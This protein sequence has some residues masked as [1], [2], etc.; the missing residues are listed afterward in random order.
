MCVVHIPSSQS[1]VLP[2]REH[3]CLRSLDLF[4]VNGTAPLS[5]TAQPDA[6]GNAVPLCWEK[7]SVDCH[8]KSFY[9]LWSHWGFQGQKSSLLWKSRRG[10]DSCGIEMWSI[11]SPSQPVEEGKF[12]RTAQS[13]PLF[14]PLT[15]T[16]GSSTR[17]GSVCV[18]FMTVSLR[19][20]GR[21]W[22]VMASSQGWS[23]SLRNS[24]FLSWSPPPLPLN[25]LSDKELTT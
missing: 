22:L 5:F 23:E 8:P 2:L 14:P 20:E 15:L 7:N 6:W 17:E 13:S 12:R 10:G 24:S 16:P 25:T 9:F 19:R 4:L 21:G 11:V 1:W 3:P 18:R